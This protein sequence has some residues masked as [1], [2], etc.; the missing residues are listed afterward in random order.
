MIRLLTVDMTVL[1]GVLGTRTLRR[2]VKYAS[3][4][5]PCGFPV[6]R[7]SSRSRDTES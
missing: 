5:T 1:L 3:D 4:S 7:S 6:A 2:T